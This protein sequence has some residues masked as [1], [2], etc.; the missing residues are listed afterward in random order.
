MKSTAHL[1]FSA[2]E[3]LSVL[4]PFEHATLSEWIQIILNLVKQF[5]IFKRQEEKWEEMKANKTCLPIS[6]LKYNLFLEHAK[7]PPNN[8]KRKNPSFLMLH[9]AEM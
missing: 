3:V 2:D 1:S 8:H 4:L 9:F 7:K 6:L 5:E